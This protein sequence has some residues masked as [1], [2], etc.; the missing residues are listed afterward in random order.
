MPNYTF[1]FKKDDILVEFC[2]T[3]KELVERQFQTWVTSASVYAYSQRAKKLEPKPQVV[4]PAAQPRPQ[5]APTPAPIVQPIAPQPK[6]ESQIPPVEQSQAE[7]SF[8]LSKEQTE[9]PEVFDKAANLLKTINLIQNPTEAQTVVPEPNFEEILEK[10]VETTEYDATKSKDPV[11]LNLINSK[12]TTDKFH[13]LMITAYYLSE[14]E[15]LERFSLKQINSKLMHNLSEVID[16][17]TLQAAINQNFIELVPDL[18]GTSEVG[19][20]RITP[21]GEDFFANKI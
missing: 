4:Q 2:T 13:Y 18:T 3:D 17:T 9:Q 15:K 19:E 11:F 16:H 12:N 20:Y 10:T 8:D 1:T 6:V 7:P 5:P 21:S 14:F